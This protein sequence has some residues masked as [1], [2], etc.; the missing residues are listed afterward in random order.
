M[1]FRR[2]PPACLPTCLQLLEQ[3]RAAQLADFEDHLEDLAADWLN[4][5]LVQG[6][7]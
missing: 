3:G 1:R 5:G 6:P 4:P 2:Q 7:A